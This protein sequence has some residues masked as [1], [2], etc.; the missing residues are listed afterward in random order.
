M[1]KPTPKKRALKGTAKKLTC[2]AER[3]AVVAAMGK[4]SGMLEQYLVA[5]GQRI[6]AEKALEKAIQQENV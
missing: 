3:N 2:G 5:K 6:N 1:R 4:E